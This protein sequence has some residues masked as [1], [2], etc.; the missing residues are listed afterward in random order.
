MAAAEPVRAA[1]RL[2]AGLNALYEVAV[3]ALSLFAP[4][5]AGAVYRLAAEDLSPTALALTRILGGLMVAHGLTLALFVRDPERV[6]PL[7]PVLLAGG[8]ANLLA[9]A[10]PCLLGELAWAQVAGSLAF[11]SL[12]VLALA[13][14]AV[15]NI[16]EKGL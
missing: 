15:K 14:Y 11:Q 9:A 12:L 1:A 2:M 5:A 10:L 7:V 3:G 16:P 8:V 13:A 6:L 4:R